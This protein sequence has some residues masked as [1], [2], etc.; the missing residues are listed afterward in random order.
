MPNHVRHDE[1]VLARLQTIVKQPHFEAN[2]NGVKIPPILV[3]T[4][5]AGWGRKGF[6]LVLRQ[7]PG[8]RTDARGPLQEER[9]E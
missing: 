3:G 2:A 6:G 9:I 5:A 7:R 8:Q 1:R 4:Y